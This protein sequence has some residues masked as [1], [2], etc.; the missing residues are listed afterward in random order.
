MTVLWLDS[1]IDRSYLT[2]TLPGKRRP[3]R[4]HLPPVGGGIRCQLLTISTMDDSNK[5]KHSFF[6][7]DVGGWDFPSISMA[8]GTRKF[9]FSSISLRRSSVTTLNRSESM[10]S[11]SHKTLT[12]FIAEDDVQGLQTYLENKKVSVDDKDEHS[13]TPLLVATM[14]NHIDVVNMLLEHKP[15]VNAVDKDGC[16]AL[17][18]ACKEGYTEIAAAVIAAGA[19]INVQ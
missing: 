3:S 9:S 19:Y 7:L 1:Q 13:W 8:D 14:G 15:N 6:H 17:I 12:T 16:T 4:W 18:L 11:L 2:A 5:P 10:V